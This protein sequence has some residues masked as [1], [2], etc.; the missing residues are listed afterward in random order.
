MDNEELLRELAEY[1]E[2]LQVKARLDGF[3]TA[4]QH[5]GNVLPRERGYFLLSLDTTVDMLTIDGYAQNE[6]QRASND[7]KLRTKYVGSRDG[8]SARIH[9]PPMA[10]PNYFADTESFIA[11]LDEALKS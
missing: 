1:A 2:R 4:L 10:Y 11:E 3:A 8:C 6:F 7:L 9:L 5:M